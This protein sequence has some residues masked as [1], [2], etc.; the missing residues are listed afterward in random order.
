MDFIIAERGSGKTTQLIKMFLED[1]EHTGIAC[2]S[3]D[4]AD[5]LR[6]LARRELVDKYVEPFLTELL[7]TNIFSHRNV[8]QHRG[9]FLNS[10]MID[11]ADII[12]QDLMG[13]IGRVTDVTATGEVY[14]IDP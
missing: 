1:P 6:H 12:L 13:G 8:Q 9:N 3:E 7:L 14:K 2:I 10:I 5:R 11:N 4:E